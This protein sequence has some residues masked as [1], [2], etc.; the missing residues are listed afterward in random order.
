MQSSSSPTGPAAP[1]APAPRSPA[2]CRQC[3]GPAL[4]ALPCPASPRGL[5][6]DPIPEVTDNA[7]RVFRALG[8]PDTYGEREHA[9]A[10]EALARDLSA[11]QGDAA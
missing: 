9:K 7:S 10:L 2:I 1:T 6:C 8:Y 5:P 3:G 4:V 11:F